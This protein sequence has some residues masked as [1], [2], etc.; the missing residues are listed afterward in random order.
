MSPEFGGGKRANR[1]G[2]GIR[3]KKVSAGPRNEQGLKSKRGKKHMATMGATWRMKLCTQPRKKKVE[4][5]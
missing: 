3:K 1:K 5:R 4:K 2:S